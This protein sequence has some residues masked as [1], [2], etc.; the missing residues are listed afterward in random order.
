MPISDQYRWAYRLQSATNTGSRQRFRRSFFA[1][2]SVLVALT[3]SGCGGGGGGTVSQTTS[4]FQVE[5]GMAQKGPLIRGSSVTINELSGSSLKPNGKSYTFEVTDNT[6]TFKPTGITFTSPYLEVTAL[7]YYFNEVSGSNSNDMVYLRGLSDL[8]AGADQAVNLNILTNLTKERVKILATR[9][10]GPLSFSSARLQAQRELAAAFQIH[11][12]SD[13][14]SVGAVSGVTQP[15]NFMELDL[16]KARAADQVLAAL[17]SV[18]SMVG[19]NGSGINEFLNQVETDLGDDGLL[20]NSLNLAVAPSK[21]FADAAKAIDWAKVA[22]NLNGFYKFNKYSAADLRQWVDT[23]GGVDMVIDRNKSATA[24]VAAGTQSLSSEYS[25]TTDDV[26]QCIRSA[27][28]SLIRNGVPSAGPVKVARGDVFRV[29]VT[30]STVAGAVAIGVIQRSVAINNAC[31]ATAPTSGSVV[32][33]RHQTTT[34]K[35]P[36]QISNPF[37]AVSAQDGCTAAVRASGSIL[38]WGYGGCVA[39]GDGTERASTEYKK[40]AISPYFMMAIRKD[41]S[42]WA[43]GENIWGQHGNGTASPATAWKRVAAA[44]TDANEVAVGRGHT[45]VT[46]GAS[47]WGAGDNSYMQLM[48]GSFGAFASLSRIDYQRSWRSIA[49]GPMQSAGVD[50]SGRLWVR[51]V[52]AATAPHSFVSDWRA[53]GEGFSAVAVAGDMLLAL[54]TDGSLWQFGLAPPAALP[55][56]PIGTGYAAVAAGGKHLLAVKRDGTLWAWGDNT[57]GQ[58]GDGTQSSRAVPTQVGTGFAAVAAG[59][60]HSVAIKADGSL[61]AWGFNWS[62]ALGTGG[63]NW[64]LTPSPVSVSP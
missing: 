62:N 55:T 23:S 19:Q 5:S 59:E 53:L 44:G 38:T 9:A 43:F 16:G 58:L 33:F 24:D 4:G 26:G 25:S 45:L 48:G 40:V 50:T 63:G 60:N 36:P 13:L 22:A 21:R 12:L 18:V 10:N 17:S 61:W 56:A 28:G 64:V 32:L 52:R 51:G 8:S 27:G 3:L 30:S 7:G 54:K 47:L 11:G 57:A 1:V 34:V 2:N 15:T 29:S 46:L 20:N 31:P 41:G 39:R 42:L 49:A 6:G 35:P 37:V 14:L